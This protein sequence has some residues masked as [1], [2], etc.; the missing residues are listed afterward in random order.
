M[1]SD[2]MTLFCDGRAASF[3]QVNI[4]VE[5]DTI[6][7]AKSA[8]IAGLGVQLLPLSEIEE[9]IA[10]GKLVLVLPQWGPPDFGIYA[11]W[12]DIGPKKALTRRLIAFFWAAR[13][14]CTAMTVKDSPREALVL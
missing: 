7:S 4:R 5:V 2:V 1:L 9:E 6:A 10:A 11:V 12:P 14:D 8:I 3:Q 13:R